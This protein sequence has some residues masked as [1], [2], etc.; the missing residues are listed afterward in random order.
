MEYGLIKTSFKTILNMCRLPLA[1]LPLFLIMGCEKKAEVTPTPPVKVEVAKPLVQ[2]T[3]IFKSYVGHVQPIVQVEVKSQVEGVMTDYYFT[4]GQTVKKG[5]LLFTIDSRP[6]E[7]QLSKANAALAQNVANLRYAE[8]VL[9]RNKRLAEE[10]YVS[11]LQFDEYITNVLVSKAAIK[12]NQADIEEAKINI[13]YCNIHAPMDSLTGMLQIDAG[14]LISNAQTT[15][16]VILN[17]ITPIYVNFSVPQKDLPTIMQFHRKN[18][19]KVKAFLPQG[20]K[21]PFEGTLNLI[22]N[23]VD[24][25]TGSI[26][27]RGIFQNEE[28]LLWP[29]EFADVHLI[30]KVQKNALLIPTEAIMTTQNGKFVFVVKEDN[31]VEMQK[32]SLGI[33]VD[34]NTIVEEG[35]SPEDRVVTRGQINLAPGTKIVI[36]KKGGPSS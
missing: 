26:W 19:L 36:Q 34:Q 2:D 24:E 7:A 1:L 32:I 5:E 16:L 9:K 6:F 27:L 8:D 11:Q 17:Q 12:Q 30:L 3:E 25:S 23:Q 28:Q 20:E 21:T 13:S 4:E 18:P 10:D 15:P 33:R 35:L 22:D 31:T 29:G 14:N